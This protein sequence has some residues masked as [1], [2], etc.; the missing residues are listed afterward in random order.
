VDERR[1]E[2]YQIEVTGPGNVKKTTAASVN[3]DRQEWAKRIG[4]LFNVPKWQM[5]ILRQTEPG[6][7]AWGVGDIPS[8]TVGESR[9]FQFVLGGS[10][11]DV[12]MEDGP[13]EYLRGWLSRELG[14]KHHPI[15]QATITQSLGGGTKTVRWAG[16]AKPLVGGQAWTEEHQL[17][18]HFARKEITSGIIAE[19]HKPFAP[20][21]LDCEK[22]RFPE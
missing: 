22:A 10:R 20:I 14:I 15:A 1:G 19:G 7:F 5:V 21:P 11:H 3:W 2:G 16:S 18:F 9:N 6:R 8:A 12:T 4:T 13:E 17:V